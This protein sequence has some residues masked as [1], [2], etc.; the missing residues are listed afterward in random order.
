M[1]PYRTKILIILIKKNKIKM[2]RNLMARTWWNLCRQKIKN[3]KNIERY[4]KYALR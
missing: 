4:L 2:K 1:N 3:L